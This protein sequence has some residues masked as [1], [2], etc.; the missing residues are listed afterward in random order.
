[1]DRSIKVVGK[2]RLFSQ[3]SIMTLMIA[4]LFASVPAISAV[5]SPMNLA[6]VADAGAGQNVLEGAPVSLDGSRSRDPDGDPLTYQWTQ[7]G[8]PGVA[9]SGAN[10]ARPSFIAP[11]VNLNEILEFRLQVSDGQ[12][13]SAPSVVRVTVMNVNQAP[14]ANAGIDQTVDMGMPVTLDGSGSMDPDG[15]LLTF[16]WTQVAGPAVTLDLADPIHPAFTAPAVPADGA[17]IS[18]QLLVNDGSIASEP[19]LV[20]VSVKNVNHAPIAHAGDDQ[21][22]PEGTVVM[23]DASTSYDPEG[24]ALTYQWTQTSGPSVVITDA[25]S[26]RASFVAPDVTFGFHSLA[27]TLTVSDGRASSSDSV[28]VTV[29]NLN[30]PPVADAGDDQVV[31]VGAGVQLNG[32]ES[33][34]PDGDALSYTWV[35]VSGPSVTLDL[36][37]PAHPSFT[38]PSVTELTDLVF[39]LVV[40]DGI[41]PSLPDQV[42]VS[43]LP[44][45]SPPECRRAK[46]EPKVLW[47]PNHKLKEIQIKVRD[48]SGRG[49]VERITVLGVTQDEPTHGLGD[50][51]TPVDAV[52]RHKKL[53]LR[54]ERDGDGNGRVYEVNFQA[55]N[56]RGEV[57]VGKV[58]VCVP[59]NKKKDSCVDDGQTF[60]S[61]Q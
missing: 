4:G 36:A 56:R 14:I 22:L 5:H 7:M 2:S 11:M 44:T 53:S 33:S 49:D 45:S 26:A 46:V 60:D 3:P 42:K 13:M 27:F 21:M 32:S 29:Q 20:N 12:L 34:D 16:Q 8:G 48:G 52:I 1:M 9:L 18:F 6:P 24:D 61:T 17:T 38:A 28:N 35:Q 50:G 19:A 47:P 39:E 37:D 30:Q 41:L 10:T 25:N 15:D 59:K 54:A 51:D 43:V 57:C 23:L 40:N 58:R 31:D 55:E